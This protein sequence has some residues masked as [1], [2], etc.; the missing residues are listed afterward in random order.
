MSVLKLLGAAVATLAFTGVA[1][2]VWGGLLTLNLR[3]TPAVPWAAIAMAGLLWLAWEYADGRWRPRRTS[4][5]RHA[6]LRARLIDPSAFALALVAGGLS[7]VALTGMWILAF[8]TG[9]MRG[10]ALPDFSQYPLQSVVAVIATAA[11]V[12]GVTEEAG[13]RGYFQSLLE[14][15]YPAWLAIVVTAL[16]LAPGHAATQGFAWPTFLFYL[17]VD[18]MLGTT[19]YLCD[20]IL[21]GI[22]V[23][24][25][26]LA[27]FFTLIWPNDARRTVGAAALDDTWF[28]IHAVQV[29]VFAVLAIMAYRRLAL[30]GPRRGSVR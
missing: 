21:P 18:A 19:A 4:A 24:T 5:A 30:T 12:G 23:H 29:V 1:S 27:A 14:R 13:F 2:G 17:L 15:R 6:L 8:Q 25:A 28:W 9:L 26:G 11:V 22:V 7:L 3:T 20:S 16:V 10:N